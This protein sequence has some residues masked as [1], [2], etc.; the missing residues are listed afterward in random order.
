MIASAANL[1]CISQPPP[2]SLLTMN[3]DERRR[4]VELHRRLYGLVDFETGLSTD[5]LA[6][7]YGKPRE[8]A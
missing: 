4:A 3:I 5:F 6:R 2:D 7:N 1:G 8:D